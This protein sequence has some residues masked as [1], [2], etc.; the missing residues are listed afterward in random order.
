MRAERNPRSRG[1][2]PGHDEN[3]GDDGRRDRGRRSG[4]DRDPEWWRNLKVDPRATVQIRR[5]TKQVRAELATAAEKARLWPEMTK[6]YRNY[7]DYVKRTSRE[8]PLIVLKP[9]GAGT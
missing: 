8:I 1:R 2:F 4:D 5:E 6:V 9:P 7:D 3:E